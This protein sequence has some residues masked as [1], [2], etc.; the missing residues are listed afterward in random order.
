ML[1]VLPIRRLEDGGGAQLRSTQMSKP[2][3]QLFSSVWRHVL[4][5]PSTRRTLWSRPRPAGSVLPPCSNSPTEEQASS[6]A[7][8]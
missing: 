3:R 7:R 2:A 8:R 1:E 4:W 5:P 6:W